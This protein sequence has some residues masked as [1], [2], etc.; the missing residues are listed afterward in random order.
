MGRRTSSSFFM[1]DHV[2]FS[3]SDLEKAKAFYTETLAPIGYALRYEFN[4]G[5]SEIVGIGSGP[6]PEVWF[7]AGGKTVPHVHF[8]FRAGTRTQVDEFYWRALAAG[9]TDNGVP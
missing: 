7:Y 2:T 8:A 3:V 1:L 9:G 5:D 6:P 4:E